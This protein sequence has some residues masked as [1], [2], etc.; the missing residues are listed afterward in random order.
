MDLLIRN[1]RV[2]DLDGDVDHPPVADMLIRDGI[3]A[4]I[5]PNLPEHAGVPE[6]DATGQLLIPGLVNA[7]YHSHDVMLRGMFE[8][9]PLDL[10]IYYSGPQNYPATTAEDLRL[11]T[12]LG[13]VDCLTNGVTTLQDMVAIPSGDPAHLD[14]IL[15]GYEASGIRASVGLQI[16]DLAAAG[17]VP[18][19]D[20]I[21]GEVGK[22]LRSPIDAE[23]LKALIE[24]TVDSG[25][26]RL[27]WGLAPSAPQRCSDDLLAWLAVIAKSRNLQTFT[28]VYE[29]RNQAVMART[30]PNAGSLISRLE[31]FGLLNENLTIAHGVWIDEDELKHLGAA[32]ANM[33]FNP[34]TNL[35]LLNGFAPIRGYAD[36]GT[37][38]ALGCDNCSGN[39]S[40]SL[41]QSMKNFA[42]YWGMQSEAGESGAA[43]RAFS[44]AT[45]GG[46]RALGLQGKIGALK[47]GMCGDVVMLDLSSSTYRPLHSALNQ[48]V[49]GETGQGIR[50]VVVGGKLA[51][52]NGEVID[53]PSAQLKTASEDART[54]MLP[55]IEDIMRRNA[56]LLAPLLEAYRRADAIP[57]SIDRYRM[58][59]PSWSCG[60]TTE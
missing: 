48:V 50:A 55:A 59:R 12:V 15:R 17:T 32:G 33:A 38:V 29:A 9:I 54:R 19:W 5:A 25:T 42:L 51:V 44:A 4:E 8:Q 41:F 37:T 23:P 56:P 49:Y 60:T 7:H 46:A 28:H 11:R 14:A 30:G 43:R 18:F 47:P 58:P 22:L 10:W 6:L 1:G 52:Q 57:L 24:S 3:I 39:D 35:K 31:R 53:H 34:A 26:D 16:G 40:Q 36:G 27:T 21:G 20:E 2:F 45:L 13:A